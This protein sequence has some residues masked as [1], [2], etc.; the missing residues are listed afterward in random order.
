[1]RC[2]MCAPRHVVKSTDLNESTV[3]RY[4]GRTCKEWGSAAVTDEAKGQ[5]SSGRRASSLDWWV[6]GV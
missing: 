6:A 4:G 3:G 1:M 5:M 2:W